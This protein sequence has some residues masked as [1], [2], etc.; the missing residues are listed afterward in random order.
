MVELLPTGAMGLVREAAA[1]LGAACGSRSET[2]LAQAS[3]QQMAALASRR[4]E[5]EAAADASRFITPRT[6]STASS[7]PM[8]V[9]EQITAAPEPFTLKRTMVNL[10]GLRSITAV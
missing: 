10:V 7:Q 9:R 3:S 2:L 4:L 5:E 8:A 6:S 1:A